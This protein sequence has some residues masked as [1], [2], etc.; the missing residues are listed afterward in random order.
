MLMLDW[1]RWKKFRCRTSIIPGI[2]V[3]QHF[4]VAAKI[5]CFL[6][7]SLVWSAR[8]TS[9]RFGANDRVRTCLTDRETSSQCRK[10]ELWSPTEL[11]C[12]LVSYVAPLWT[13]LYPTE[14]CCTLLSYAAFFWA[15]LHHIVLWCTS[16][17]YS[18]PLS[19]THPSEPSVPIELCCTLLSCAAP[20]RAT[21]HSTELCGPLVSYAAPLW[22][23]LHPI[24]LC[25]NL[26]NDAAR[27]GATLH[28][29]ELIC[30]LLSYPAPSELGLPCQVMVHPTELRCTLL[31][32][33]APSR[34]WCFLLS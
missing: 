20:S 28:P 14:L 31:N 3:L 33:Y 23:R 21:P 29:T 13:K 26:L 6:S 11:S 5:S 30:T 7:S 8:R 17:S 25:C 1:H 10:T 19:Y 9:M 18:H 22:A 16:L 24:E 15:K 4:L 34:L 2:L 32:Y 27:F 12:T